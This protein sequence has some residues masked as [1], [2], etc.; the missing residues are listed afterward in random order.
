MQKSDEKTTDQN[1]RWKLKPSCAFPDHLYSATH[2]ASQGM[3]S[4]TSPEAASLLLGCILKNQKKSN[5]FSTIVHT[6]FSSIPT[7][8]PS[9]DLGR[10]PN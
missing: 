10:F 6:A 8:I 7:D 2:G 1:L 4:P 3:V 5:N 9:I